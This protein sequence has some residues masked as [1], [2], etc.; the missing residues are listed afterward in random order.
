MTDFGRKQDALFRLLCHYLIY[1]GKAT[2][3]LESCSDEKNLLQTW[4]TQWNKPAAFTWNST[5]GLEMHYRI[6][7]PAGYLIA[8]SEDE[9]LSTIDIDL[10]DFDDAALFTQDADLLKC[11]ACGTFWADLDEEGVCRSCHPTTQDG[12]GSASF[13]F[14]MNET[15]FPND[16]AF[17]TLFSLPALD[18]GFS[19][20][21]ITGNMSG[22]LATTELNWTEQQTSRD[23]TTVDRS[24]ETFDDPDQG[25]VSSIDRRSS[26]SVY[27]KVRVSNSDRGKRLRNQT[28]R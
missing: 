19:H 2:A 12:E 6:E 24:L 27:H 7:P 8:S 14:L 9:S 22:S 11:T 13:S 17:S 1:I 10:S 25:D 3:L 28:K 5:E 20:T 15:D 21:Y 18:A 16:D 26:T 23:E 4:R